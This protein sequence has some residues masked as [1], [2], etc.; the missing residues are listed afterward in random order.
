MPNNE[1]FEIINETKEALLED[2]K[3]NNQRAEALDWSMLVRS[4]QAQGYTE[5]EIEIEKK[6]FEWT[7]GLSSRLAGKGLNKW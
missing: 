2:A 4:M 6:L 7:I 3:D 1:F 5:E